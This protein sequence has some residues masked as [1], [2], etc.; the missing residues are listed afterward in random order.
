M[1]TADAGLE[2]PVGFTEQKALQQLARIEAQAIK[3]AQRQQQ[4]FV[5]ANQA[6]VQSFGQMSSAAQAKLQNVSYQMQDIFVQVS[7]GT[8]AARA[9]SQQL[10][11][12]LSGFGALGA[13]LGLAAAV[14]IPLASSLLG[15]GDAAKETAD[16]IDKLDGAVKDYRSAVDRALAPTTDLIEKYG[17][18]AGAARDL[19]E[20]I[21]RL[22]RLE[23]VR[24]LK[25]STEKLSN[26]LGGVKDILDT[27]D[28]EKALGLGDSGLVQGSIKRLNDEFGLT[29]AQAREFH[30]L[31]TNA[32]AAQNVHDQ[33]RAMRELAHFLENSVSSGGEFKDQ[34]MVGAKAAAQGALSALE[35]AEATRQAEN[36][37]TGLA[38]AVAKVSFSDAITG[39]ST[40]AEV[41][42]RAGNL[43][44]G[45]GRGISEKIRE[46]D[47]E[48]ANSGILALIKRRESGG[49]YNA[50]LDNGAYTG[51]ARDLVNMTINEVLEMQRQ[52]LAHPANTKNSSAAG[53]YQIVRKTLQGLVSDLGLT[54]EELYSKEMQDRLAMQLLRRRRGQGLAG[55]R[56]EW[57]GLK[58]VD[59][60]TVQTALG[61]QSIERIDP[62]VAREQARA[63]DEAAKAAQRQADA[64][65]SKAE[66]AKAYG[67]RLSENLLTEQQTA[68][69]EAQRAQAIAAINASG[70]TDADKAAAIA[71]VNAEMQRQ[72]TIMGLV[73]EAQR[74]GVDLDARMIDSTLTYGD[75]IN[76]LGDAQYNRAIA[77]QQAAASA[78]Q[79]RQ[80][81]DFA[82]QQI[83]N[84]QEGLVDAILA[85]ES[86]SD[87][88]GN[89][90]MALAK[91]SL[92]AALF[93]SG[94]MASMFNIPQGGGLMNGIGQ[95]FGFG[96]ARA[97]G[98]PVSAGQAYL[99]GERGPEII[100]P[101]GAGE[102]IPNHKLGGANMHV[103]FAPNISIAPGVTREELA[104]TM[105]QARREYEENFLPMLKK[106]FPEFQS[107]AG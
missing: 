68:Q 7:S 35:L 73:A 1:A 85:G 37:A 32:Q 3:A 13:A 101:R 65:R 63:A 74:R 69:L 50:T 87:V 79:L 16:A 98:G 15:V 34:M 95:F 90:A 67:Q 59:D 14:A 20:Q 41:L 46:G 107:R 52:M 30:R 54:G 57:E 99:V 33:A 66:E 19:F 81:Q 96:G 56:A 5:Q 97:A 80:A 62:E 38:D 21:A 12:L 91:A 24:T 58:Y 89:V 105:A 92:Q 93:G 44:R 10:P 86:F 42:S 9:L 64:I 75:A 28:A 29:V 106:K 48:A 2:I 83:A 70:M 8:S 40:L 27:I 55:L 77:D 53:A 84:L 25:D 78:D 43:V 100:V 104:M 17:F 4:K 39:A 60:D 102:V 51:G 18:A 49:N 36:D 72:V 82:T 103:P 47:T 71:Q 22:S 6:V 11:Q 76:A 26:S 94:P 45:I 31:L 61:Q 23:A 88:L